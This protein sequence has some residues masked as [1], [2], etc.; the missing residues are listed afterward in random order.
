[1]GQCDCRDN[2]DKVV[3]TTPL[4]RRL[5]DVMYHRFNCNRKTVFTSHRLSSNQNHKKLVD[6]I[7]NKQLKIRSSFWPLACLT[8]K[9]VPGHLESVIPDELI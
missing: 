3:R 7:Q 8:V 1:M 2:R 9:L 6:L 4:S 5:A